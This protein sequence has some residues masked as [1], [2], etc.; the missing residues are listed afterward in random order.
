MIKMKN[1]HLFQIILILLIAISV[2]CNRENTTDC[3][4]TL[5]IQNNSNSDVYYYIWSDTTLDDANN[6][7]PGN[8]STYKCPSK[9][10]KVD[11]LRDCWETDY[12][13]KALNGKISTYIFDAHIIETNS[14]DTI[15]KKYMILKRYELTLLDL[16][17]LNWTIT[18]P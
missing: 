6:P 14:W 10:S 12:F 11:R 7:F 4:Y 9:Q 15:V 3:H 16:D 17:S 18:Y 5:T 8:I 2:T 1:N 13:P